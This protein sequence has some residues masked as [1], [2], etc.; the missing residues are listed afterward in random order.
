M[1]L[2]FQDG[3]PNFNNNLGALVA[4]P[5]NWPSSD[6]VN[7]T[8]SQQQTQIQPNGTATAALTVNSSSSDQ[9]QAGAQ[10]DGQTVIASVPVSDFTFSITPTTITVNGGVTPTSTP[11]FTVTVT[12]VNGFNF[13]VTIQVGTNSIGA[14][15]TSNPCTISNGSGSVTITAAPTASTSPGTYPIPISAM[16]V[17]NN[18]VTINK[19]AQTANVVVADFQLSFTQS[20]LSGVVGQKTTFTVQCSTTSGFNGPVTLSTDS[21]IAA[22]PP[23]DQNPLQCPGSIGSPPVA[24]S[25][26]TLM[27]TTGGSFAVNVTGTSGNQSTGPLQHTISGTLN[28]PDFSISLN[29]SS[30][31]LA[32]QFTQ[33]NQS[34]QITITS[35]GGF[36]GAVTLSC[37]TP[38]PFLQGVGGGCGGTVTVPS[39]GSATGSGEATAQAGAQ[40]GT[41]S[42]PVSATSNGVTHTAN[43][44]IAV[45]PLGPP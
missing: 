44:F 3:N 19:P 34:F 8:L 42:M 38:T 16:S 18:S 4:L 17:V 7:G 2:A 26:L 24:S 40:Q 43:L 5:V 39:G 33:V 41:T 13:P 9:S 22:N 1:T 20:T 10:V 31:T 45:T 27:P 29:P 36:S 25:G 28:V 35:L 12:P 21:S 14:T 11:T 32:P 6:V 15:C 37:G 23:F 30:V